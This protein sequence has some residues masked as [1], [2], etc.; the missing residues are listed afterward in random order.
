MLGVIL[1]FLKMHKV[2]FAVQ[3]ASR[4]GIIVTPT[5]VECTWFKSQHETEIVIVFSSLLGAFSLGRYRN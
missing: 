4:R 1:A 2:F 5:G 3:Y